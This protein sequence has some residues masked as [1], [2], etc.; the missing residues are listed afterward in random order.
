MT[1]NVTSRL[2]G[3]KK[4]GVETEMESVQERWEMAAV[5]MAL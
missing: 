4:S 1:S 3:Y 2:Q 5:E